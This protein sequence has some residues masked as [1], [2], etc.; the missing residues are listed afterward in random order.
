MIL[1]VLKNILLLLFL[2]GIFQSPCIGV[3][4]KNLYMALICK[5]SHYPVAIKNQTHIYASNV[6]NDILIE[7][8]NVY[9]SR[10]VYWASRKSL[11][12]MS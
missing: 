6:N 11:L 1:K 12:E 8:V 2:N 10:G 5:Y 4:V 3:D 7:V 9:F